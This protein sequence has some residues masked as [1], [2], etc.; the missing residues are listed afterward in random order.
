MGDIYNIKYINGRVDTVELEAG[1]G[2][3]IIT[4]LPMPISLH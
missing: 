3:D 4:F 2:D 1:D